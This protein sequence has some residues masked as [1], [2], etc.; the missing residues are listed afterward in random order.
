MSDTLI[1]PQ[2]K[3]IFL[4]SGLPKGL[5]ILFEDHG[6]MW[7]KI[8]LLREDIIRMDDEAHAQLKRGLKVAR[9]RA[10]VMGVVTGVDV[11]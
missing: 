9:Q 11:R 2:F 1:T 8:I 6:G 5:R 3:S 4:D 10:K 7:V